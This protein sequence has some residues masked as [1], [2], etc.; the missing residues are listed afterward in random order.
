M[1]LLKWL[2]MLAGSGAI[3][4]Y[5]TW[6]YATREEPVAGR[7][8]AAVLRAAALATAWLILLNPSV[9]AGES[10]AE[11]ETA[12]VL[13]ASLSMSRPSG[14]EAASIWS[15]AVD[16]VERYS[17]VWVFGGPTPRYLDG[18]SLPAEPQYATSLL[19][20]AI[21][22]TAASGTRRVVVY[23]DGM[24]TD[25]REALDEA[26]RRGLILSFVDLEPSV[27]DAAISTVGASGW[28]QSGDTVEVR[29]EIIASAVEADSLRVEVVDEDGRIRAAAW[30]P[31]PQEGRFS[32]AILAFGL[33][34]PAG[35]RRFVVRLFP[36]EGDLEKRND[37]RV[38]Y[39]R[40]TEQA[41]GPVLI[42]LQPDWE[43]S[44]LVENLD[45]LTDAPTTVYVWLA[46]SL[47]NLDGY[48]RVSRATVQRRA[49]A[50]PL[51]IVHAFGADSP[52]WVSETVRHSTRLLVF[53]IGSR[54]FD[55]PGWGVRVGPP[56]SGEWYAAADVPPSPLAL[57]LGGVS[58]EALPPLLAVRLVETEGGWSPLDLR[59]L[60][61]G[62]PRP[63]VVLGG[64]GA[65]RFAVAAAEGFWRWAFRSGSGRQLYRALWT[66]VA[67]WLV[68]R[69]SV[70]SGLEPR[71]RVVTRG[72][73]LRWIAP[74]GTDSLTID[75]VAESGESAFS[76]TVAA[77]DSV[78]ARLSPGRY[79]Y[80]AQAYVDTR[81]ASAA[82]GPV[83]V[84]AFSEEL[85]PRPRVSLEPLAPETQEET[86]AS[87][88]GGSRGLAT[89]GWPYLI[90]IA[91]F[92]AEWALRRWSGLR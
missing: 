1:S 82:E 73:S 80:R 88:S 44:F 23:S 65:R 6:W 28:V 53:P 12:A 36:P 45:R 11:S 46:D 30:A 49:L 71:R 19:V 90:L 66:G 16:S 91:L 87:G 69:E 51:L 54:G 58:L 27:P 75:L 67:G 68:S 34:G 62:E 13:D 20:P 24:V 64:D 15:Q 83:E 92:C 77:G 48:G 8:W 33:S 2:L 70:G 35:F 57:D 29:A 78:S 9:P 89:L 55:L 61:R 60:R 21:R 18:D 72:E 3:V 74:E 43:P 84:E 76:Q 10:G 47:L 86:R 42:S 37:E 4:A 5:A 39:V 79:R 52:E 41:I 14:V 26:R 40:V 59:R 17:D 25:A 7:K 22:A 31:V 50:A 63:A 38:I 32:A 85:A 81:Q 56:A